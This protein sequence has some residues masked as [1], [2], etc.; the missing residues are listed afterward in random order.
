M[1]GRSF[2]CQNLRLD[3]LNSEQPSEKEVRNIVKI[4][5]EWSATFVLVKNLK[6]KSKEMATSSVL[7]LDTSP[8]RQKLGLDGLISEQLS[9]IFSEVGFILKIDPKRSAT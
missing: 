9:E 6:E 4:D 1:L 8:W 2:W 7:K 3:H 5:P